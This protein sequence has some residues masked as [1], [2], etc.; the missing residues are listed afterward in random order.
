MKRIYN[1]TTR[2]KPIMLID[3]KKNI[4]IKLV[5]FAKICKCN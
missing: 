4:F 3:I 2:L 1:M 5:L